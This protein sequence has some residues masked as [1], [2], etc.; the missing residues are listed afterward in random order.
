ML[1]AVRRSGRIGIHV[2]RDIGRLLVE[3]PAGGPRL[4]R[5][6]ASEVRDYLGA[7]WAARAGD[8]A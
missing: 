2:L 4:P 3:H 1:T 7:T 6:T 8:V 5:R